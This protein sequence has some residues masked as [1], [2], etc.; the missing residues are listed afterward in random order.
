MHIKSDDYNTVI[1]LAVN[2]RFFP[3]GPKIAIDNSALTFLPT[4]RL[5][6]L[7]STIARRDW[8]SRS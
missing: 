7:F 4:K 3:K 2:R 1:I 6:T 5:C 8:K